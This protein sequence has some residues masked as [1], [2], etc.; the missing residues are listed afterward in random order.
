MARTEQIVDQ[1]KNYAISNKLRNPHYDSSSS[2][3]KTIGRIKVFSIHKREREKMG[4][5]ETPF[6][7]AAAAVQLIF[8]P[9]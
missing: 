3:E 4:T 1:K 9:L 6:Q 7:A 5:S 8:P 2:C